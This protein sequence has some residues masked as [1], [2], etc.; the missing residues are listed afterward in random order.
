[1]NK[2]LG[3]KTVCF[4]KSVCEQMLT[5][6]RST[7]RASRVSRAT[8]R[9]A[10]VPGPPRRTRAS[11]MSPSHSQ[12]ERWLAKAGERSG[13]YQNAPGSVNSRRSG[14]PPPDNYGH[15][16]RYGNDEYRARGT[17]RYASAESEV[18]R[19]VVRSLRAD[20][21]RTIRAPPALVRLRR[22]TAAS[23]RPVRKVAEAEFRSRRRDSDVESDVVF[24]RR[25]SR[26]DGTT[27]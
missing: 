6:E 21:R 19:H 5:R 23:S 15:S 14:D 4:P 7:T 22:R 9:L 13:A 8:V 16:E 12:A 1:M 27:D 17:A 3:K 11:A 10:R 26:R 2:S 24:R 20:R 18:R 25:R